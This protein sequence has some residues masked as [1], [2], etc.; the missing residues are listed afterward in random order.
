MVKPNGQTNGVPSHSLDNA[1]VAGRLEEVAD[2]LEAQGANLF[3]VRAYRSG[4]QTVRNLNRQVP[5]ILAAEGVEGLLRLPGIGHSLARSIEQLA[6]T[7]RLG[8][9]QRLRG[10][11]GPEH[12]FVTLPGIGLEMASRIHEHL[13]VETLQDLEVAAYDGRLSQVPGMGN[14][15]VRAIK[16]TLAARFRRPPPSVETPP[17]PALTDQ[18]PVGELLQIDQEYREK[19]EAGRLTRIA[20]R[21]FNPTGTAWLPVLHTIRGDRHYTALYSNTARAHELGMTHDWVVVYRDD[22]GGSGQWTVI[23]ARYGA[24]RGRRIVRGREAECADY[25]A[26]QLTEKPSDRLLFQ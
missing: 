1:Q 12:L 26:Q 6:E 24:L 5:E 9:L 17:R 16:E 20:P 4:A 22:H 15:R 10:E 25:Y 8:L 7:G 13:G 18:P 14:K 3:R 11:A 19:A 21:R 23:T 2:L